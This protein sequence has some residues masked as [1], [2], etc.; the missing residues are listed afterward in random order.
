MKE[1]IATARDKAGNKE[2]LVFHTGNQ[3]P[4]QSYFNG[5]LA[6]QHTSLKSALDY[7]RLVKMEIKEA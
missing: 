6:S 7:F 2:Y 5:C 3:Y 1:L 4:F